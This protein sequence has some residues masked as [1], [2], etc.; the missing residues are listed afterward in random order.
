[1]E[2]EISALRLICGPTDLDTFQCEDEEASWYRRGE[3]NTRG[4]IRFISLS[5]TKSRDSSVAFKH[6]DKVEFGL[7]SPLF[8]D[9]PK[10]LIMGPSIALR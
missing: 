3:H 7:Q 1:M 9:C 8:I 5:K 4:N 6:Y 10:G 2:N